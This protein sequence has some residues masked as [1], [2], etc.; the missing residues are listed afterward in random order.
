MRP[1]QIEIEYAN[2]DIAKLPLE[3]ISNINERFDCC[4]D[5]MVAL[6]MEREPIIYNTD[7]SNSNKIIH[8]F[9]VIHG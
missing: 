2:E 4:T 5:K 3:I 7:N 1:V 9:T 6:L 8:S